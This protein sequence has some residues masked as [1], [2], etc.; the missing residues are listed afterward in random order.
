M[1]NLFNFKRKK[2]TDAM[3]IYKIYEN[4]DISKRI[5]YIVTS[6]YKRMI[7][8]AEKTALNGETSFI[9]D[10]NIEESDMIHFNI[11]LSNFI[12]K[13]VDNGFQYSRHLLSNRNR[14]NIYFSN[15]N[16]KYKI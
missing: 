15:A 9:F 14:L 6:E 16:P 4:V 7:Y 13:L 1:I 11:I 5:N 2:E 8:L 10:L 3:R 12:T